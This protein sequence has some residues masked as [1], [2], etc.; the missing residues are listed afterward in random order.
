MLSL[1]VRDI[2]VYHVGFH[3]QHRKNYN[4]MLVPF[5]TYLIWKWNYND[6]LKIAINWIQF[7]CSEKTGKC[8]SKIGT[9][10]SNCSLVM[11]LLHFP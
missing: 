11:K 10:Y 9:K 6:E 7:E 3:D 1:V 4:R 2:L 8:L 5:E